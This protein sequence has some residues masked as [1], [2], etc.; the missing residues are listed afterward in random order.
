MKSF[1]F[2]KKNWILFSNNKLSA[3]LKRKTRTCNEP[4]IKILNNSKAKITEISY[5]N[6]PNFS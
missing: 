3:I 5:E 2:Y 4:L 6:F 1:N